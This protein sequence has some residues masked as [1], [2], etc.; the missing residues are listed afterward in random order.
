MVG[1]VWPKRCVLECDEGDRSVAC[2]EL[3]ESRQHR[4]GGAK[5][6]AATSGVSSDRRTTVY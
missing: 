5:R 6:L 4:S 1:S 2:D 3:A